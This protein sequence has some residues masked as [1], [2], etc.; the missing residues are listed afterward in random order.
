MNDHDVLGVNLNATKEEI[1][2]QF[3]K[4]VI[5]SHPDKNGNENDFI[6]LCEARDRLLTKADN[7]CFLERSDPMSRR[8]ESEND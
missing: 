1:V 4:K 8:F 2:K 3:R 7:F 6:R 5:T